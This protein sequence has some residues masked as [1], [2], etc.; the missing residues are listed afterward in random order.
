[1]N[2]NAPAR[3]F[4]GTMDVDEFT[5]FMQTRPK[6]EHW[7]LIEG[8]AVMMASPTVVHQRIAHNLC[9]LLTSAFAARGLELFAYTGLSVRTPGLTNFQPEPD[10]VVLPGDAS[11][12]L[13][14]E[15][16]QLA[17]EVLSPSN[18]RKEIDLKLNRYREAPANLYS[19]V[20]ESRKF[21]VEI[22][23]RSRDWHMVRLTNP[24]DFIEMPEFGLRC[25]LADIYRG[26]P[27]I[28]LRGRS[29]SRN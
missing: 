22:Y 13:Y 19:V 2:V 27:L 21:L 20:I 5:A 6:G 25:S 8:V 10:V 26:T 17:V 7:D 4:S 28:P 23:A 16:F 1:M 12:D 14:S 24:D 18:T 15:H 9:N 29:A 3:P 11:Y